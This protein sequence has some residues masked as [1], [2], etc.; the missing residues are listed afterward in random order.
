V[1]RIR[2]DKRDIISVKV[3]RKRKMPVTVLL[4]AIL[5]SGVASG[6]DGEGHWCDDSDLVDHGHSEHV[7]KR[8]SVT[9]EASFRAQVLCALRS[10]KDSTRNSKEAL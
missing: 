2:A 7:R 6:T 8:L 4:R 5:S 1:A 9:L 10:D 3:D